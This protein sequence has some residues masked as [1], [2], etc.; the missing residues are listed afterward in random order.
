MPV[1]DSTYQ[2]PFFLPNA[3]FETIVPALF[4]KVK[5]VPYQRQRIDL[6][7]GDFLD[8]DWA[9]RP[10]SRSLAI[11]THGLEGDTTRGYVRGMA[12]MF[13]QQGWNVLA[14]NHRGCS[15][16]PNRLKRFY[17]SGSTEDLRAVIAY[18]LSLEKYDEIVL[19]GFSLGGNMTLKYLG[20]E[21]SQT[22]S[23]IQKAIVY[24]VPLHLSSCSASLREAKNWIY[25][26]R[27]KKDLSQK[28]K[29][30]ALRMPNQ[31]TTQYLAQIQ[32][33][34][35]FDNFYT[36]PLHGF[37][38]AED[39]YEKS[40]SIYYVDKIQRPTLIVNAQNDPFL[41]PPCFPYELFEG[42]ENVYFE[43]PQTGGHCGFTATG[44]SGFYWSE[45]RAWEFVKAHIHQYS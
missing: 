44:K 26:Q 34:K 32:T 22:P 36:A 45:L 40:S 30:K 5:G 43:A 24:S 28:V 19:I 18:A 11:I 35:D 39:Y 33:L 27:F 13:Y 42:L 20:E 7:D 21:G 17:H 31:I 2:K 1:I 9:H 16:E 41:A 14:W 15:G 12:K 8:L 6:P 29:N 3:H 25:A 10:R 23:T 4:R 37:A 38:D